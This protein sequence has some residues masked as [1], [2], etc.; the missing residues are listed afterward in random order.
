MSEPQDPEKQRAGDGG[1]AGIEQTSRQPFDT[2]DLQRIPTA[3][4][5]DPPYR[6]WWVMD[7]D[8]D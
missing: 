2:S 7:G 1:N 4:Q 8:T 3:R 5:D 6:D